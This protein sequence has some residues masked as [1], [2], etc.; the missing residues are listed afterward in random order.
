MV[1]ILVASM[2]AAGRAADAHPRAFVRLCK[3]QFVSI[4]LSVAISFDSALATF[5]ILLNSIPFFGRAPCD[6]Y[7]GQ[8]KKKEAFVK[9]TI[10]IC[11][12]TV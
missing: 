4:L 11:S 8:R 6:R 10:I 7:P 5:Y 12:L 3:Q 2:L 9:K 1:I